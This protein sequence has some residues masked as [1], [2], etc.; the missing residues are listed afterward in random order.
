MTDQS[1]LLHILG[2]YRRVSK[3]QSRFRTLLPG[4]KYSLP[5]QKSKVDP[6]LFMEGQEK[7]L[8]LLYPPEELQ[9]Q[10]IQQIDGIGPFLSQVIVEKVE[11]GKSLQGGDERNH[12][13]PSREYLSNKSIF[14]FL[15]RASRDILELIHLLFFSFLERVSF[16]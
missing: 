9:Y 12:F 5:P 3:D 4:E 14:F 15:R 1:E 6:L 7:D 8:S 13:P 16:F 2:V 10:L 11:E